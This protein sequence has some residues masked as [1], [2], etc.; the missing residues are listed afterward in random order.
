MSKK[1]KF[2]LKKMNK[3]NR[4]RLLIARGLELISGD[5]A[6]VKLKKD[7]VYLA[8]DY[9]KVAK[10]ELSEGKSDLEIYNK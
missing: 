3:F 8:K 4:T 9:I 10:E 5:K 6:C 2:D 1:E 7:K